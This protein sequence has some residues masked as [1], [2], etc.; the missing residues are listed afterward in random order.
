MMI[1]HLLITKEHLAGHVITR[2]IRYVGHYV[3]SGPNDQA[4]PEEEIDLRRHNFLRFAP[5]TKD[6]M[7]CVKFAEM[8]LLRH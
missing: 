3:V 1:N 6:G 4:I 7:K 2:T 5:Y 8:D